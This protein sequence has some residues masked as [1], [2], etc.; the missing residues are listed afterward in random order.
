MRPKSQVNRIFPNYISRV[1]VPLEVLDWIA[2]SIRRQDEREA[3]AEKSVLKFVACNIVVTL[4]V[5][6]TAETV[7]SK[8]NTPIVPLIRAISCCS[9]LFLSIL[10]TVLSFRTEATFVSI[11]TASW[12]YTRRPMSTG[13]I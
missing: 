5:G 9:A 7:H 10:L 11:I 8:L 1:N 2:L 3:T 12:Q 6:T 13:L 4:F